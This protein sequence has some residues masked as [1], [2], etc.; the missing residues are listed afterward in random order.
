MTN[1]MYR[2]AEF[3]PLKIFFSLQKYFKSTACSAF[4]NKNTRQN[5]TRSFV[6]CL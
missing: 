5:S 6:Q 3:S 1:L 4:K 2:R